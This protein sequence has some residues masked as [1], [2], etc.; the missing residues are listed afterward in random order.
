[1]LV[2]VVGDAD[3]GNDEPDRND[4]VKQRVSDIQISRSD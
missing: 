3:N 1:M 4:V 2:G